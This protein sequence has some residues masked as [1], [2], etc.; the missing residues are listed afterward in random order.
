[1]AALNSNPQTTNFAVYAQNSA[2]LRDRAAVS[3][4]DVGVRVAGT[5]PFLVSGYELALVNDA[6]VDTSHNVISNRL[7]LQTRAHVG[8]VQVN[9][10]NNDGGSYSHRY[11]FPSAMPALPALAS[12]SPGTA[13]LAVAANATVVASPG[14]YGAGTIGY[15]GVLRLRGGVY[16]L[17]SLQLDNEARIEALAPVQVRVAGRFGAFDRVWIGAASGA[18]LTAGDLRIE[19]G[20]RNGSSGSLTDSPKAAVFGNDATV[21]GVMLVPNGTLQPG[22]RATMVGAY[23]ARDVY[24]DIDSTVTYQSG[25]GP[26]GCLQSCDDGNPCTI[27]ACSVGTCVH[28]PSAAGTSCADSNLCNGAETCN[29]AGHCQ[30]G[31]PIPCQAQDSCHLAGVC[32]PATGACTNPAKPA[33]TVCRPA[34]GV[35]DVAEVCDGTAAGCPAD[36]F[37]SASTECRAS[38]GP[39]DPAESCTGTSADCPADT[40]ASSSTV[41]RPSTG[42]CDAPE[43]CTGDSGACPLDI[44]ACDPNSEASWGFAHLTNPTRA[45]YADTFDPKQRVTALDEL[46]TWRASLGLPH[47]DVQNFVCVD[48]SPG[49]RSCS[50]NQVPSTNPSPPSGNDCY[51]TSV[52]PTNVPGRVTGIAIDPANNQRIFITTVG[53]I[54][55]SMTGG[56]Q[57][58]RVSDS[59]VAGVVGSVAINGSE[60]LVGGG[61]SDR[62]NNYSG[63]LISN[64]LWRST[65]NGD[66]GTWNRIT[67]PGVTRI[68][69]LIVAPT[70]PHDVFATGSIL[71]FRGVHDAAGGLTFTLIEYD[72]PRDLRG[73]I[74]VDF[75]KSPLVVYRASEQNGVSRWDE[76]Y[77]HFLP[78]GSGL[79]TSDVGNIAIALDSDAGILYAQVGRLSNDRVL[80]IFQI[81]TDNSSGTNVWTH[82]AGDDAVINDS[83]NKQTDY[84]NVVAVNPKTHDLWSGAVHLWARLNGATTF[85]FVQE[86]PGTSVPHRVHDDIQTVAFDPVEPGAV[87]VGCDGGL[88][89]STDTS[90]TSWHWTEASHGVVTTQFFK[91]AIQQ[92]TASALAGGTQDNG[93]LLT[94][95]NRTW[96]HPVT[97]DGQWVGLD[98]KDS[99]TFFGFGTGNPLTEV[100]NP[101][102]GTIGASLN[103]PY[104]FDPGAVPFSPL[105]ADDIVPH[106]AL[107]QAGTVGAGIDGTKPKYLVRT[108]DGLNWKSILKVAE[109]NDS[110]KVTSLASA[111][112]GT[113]KT[114]YVG[115]SKPFALPPE[116]SIWSTG[117]GDAA[118][119]DWNTTPTGL[120]ADL[121]PNGIAVSWSHP[122]IAYG[123]YGGNA[124]DTSRGNSAFRTID[125]GKNWK[126]L[127]MGSVP[128]H[129]VFTGV[130]VDPN[131]EDVIY[132][133]AEIGVFRGTITGE[134]DKEFSVTW[135]PFDD[136]LPEGVEVNWIQ[137]NKESGELTIG[138]MGHGAFRRNIAAN[139]SCSPI[140]L[141]VRDNAFDRGVLPS[142]YGLPN[143]EDPVAD[144]TPGRTAFY[145]PNDA[146][147]AM[148]YWWKSADIR[149]DVP[150]MVTSPANQISSPDHVEVQTC[151]I[152]AASCPP[153]TIVDQNPW[154]GIDARAYVN[155][156]NTGVAPAKNVRVAALWADASL[157]LPSLPPTF[158]S[159]TFK[160]GDTTCGILDESTGWNWVDENEHCKLLSAVNPDEPAVAQ[161]LWLPVPLTAARHSC[162]LTIVESADDPIPA[163]I[164]AQF[165]PADIVPGDR[166]IALRNLQV[167]DQKRGPQLHSLP[168]NGTVSIPN[169]GSSTA[170]TNV[171][172]DGTGVPPGGYVKFYLDSACGIPASGN[173]CVPSTTDMISDVVVCDLIAS[174][175]TLPLAIP[176][177]TACQGGVLFQNLDDHGVTA[178]VDMLAR[179]EGKLLGGASFYLRSAPTTGPDSDGD[180]VIDARDNCIGVANPDQ[181]DAVGAGIGSACPIVPLL[182]YV[183]DADRE[184][185]YCTAHFGYRNGDTVVR[186]VD[187]GKFNKFT[188]GRGDRGQPSAFKP[189]QQDDV[190]TVDFDMESTL[191]WRLNGIEVTAAAGSEDGC[192]PVIPVQ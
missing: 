77:P 64:A 151:P 33:G 37:A 121:H 86:R 57:W 150:S 65:S 162:M 159:Q 149:I 42:A 132:V 19:V 26:S 103:V 164:R 104:T 99:S 135:M 177:G 168:A 66:P 147:A 14:S 67:L 192:A 90:S 75:S 114:F 27:D 108:T 176:P 8:D 31:T 165:S 92:A 156:S 3:G 136:G 15:R 118:V 144:T 169:P 13:S 32:N 152:T 95:G 106:A 131:S 133:A 63:G 25:L 52:G 100:A 138:S 123:V 36:A 145:K 187:A 54:W 85:D 59:I 191:T 70:E 2:T 4:G 173:G 137:T 61:D 130:A 21:H 128:S 188:T 47:V 23:I 88:Y 111:P 126:S 158:W 163:T 9:Q 140:S 79:P 82:V 148:L 120:P 78:M 175:A 97:G 129:A 178:R 55:R 127:N 91:T 185:Y 125:G 172:V 141:L 134:G 153:Q 69:R 155:V 181:A 62:S 11:P 73:D 179:R 39:C 119:P 71:V 10:L 160:S 41:C 183:E 22:Q 139:A 161:F 48:Q 124:T 182:T 112:D 24:V 146:D 113:F 190:F 83:Y 28:S 35:C 98:A 142:P 56:R 51:W 87:Y 74:A 116:P 170:L 72:S 167:E 5:G 143:P 109:G 115:V 58:Q 189:G 46:S 122:N 166:H 38:T 96:Y 102:P 6:H 1:V 44:P 20:G 45:D 81:S 110:R 50:F 157:G 89:K 107:A 12:V 68:T 18:T 186:T 30:A 184:G 60:I 94:F 93:S 17:A 154:A 16:H 171:V 40:L 53:G 174:S 101:V 84:D 7:L 43:Y 76:S 105:I 180:G 29:G 117:N 49:Q 80:G 34:A